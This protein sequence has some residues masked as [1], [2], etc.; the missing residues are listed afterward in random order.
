MSST[1]YS[2]IQ[3]SDL[4]CK[5]SRKFGMNALHLCLRR[6]KYQLVFNI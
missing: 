5:Q 4:Q 3:L 2:E 1:A 6:I